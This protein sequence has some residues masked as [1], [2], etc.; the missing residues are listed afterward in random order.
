MLLGFAH[1]A[2]KLNIL[3]PLGS[4]VKKLCVTANLCVT[5][6]LMPDTM[7]SHYRIERRATFMY[8]YIDKYMTQNMW[9][10]T[11]ATAIMEALMSKLPSIPQLGADD[12][13]IDPLVTF[14]EAQSGSSNVQEEFADIARKE[15]MP[16]Q[17]PIYDA[18]FKCYFRGHPS[19]LFIYL[20]TCNISKLVR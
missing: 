4:R 18:I 17:K 9:D 20:F 8:T 5:A 3:H 10:L 13:S 19:Y 6:A 14:S 11:N 15:V 7:P 1:A 2:Q 16:H 12:L